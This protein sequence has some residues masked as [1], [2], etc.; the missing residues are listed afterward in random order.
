MLTN[1]LIQDVSIGYYR[2]WW[3]NSPVDGVQLTPRYNFPNF[4]LGAT[5]FYP[6]IFGQD[7]PSFRYGLAWHRGTHD[8]KF[9]AEMLWRNDNTHW[10]NN[11]RGT[12]TFNTAL[13]PAEI[14]R[15]FPW[16]AANNP[17]KWDFSGLDR[18]VNNVA[19]NFASSWD[20]T[21]NTHAVQ[22]MAGSGAARLIALKAW[23]T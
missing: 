17:G 18:D 14:A 8:F 22:K 19:Q 21:I 2:Y 3:A 16:E 5:N 13:T 4:S 7:Q 9:G 6:Q 11:E 10:P 20:T 15:R 12:I 23:P 1:N